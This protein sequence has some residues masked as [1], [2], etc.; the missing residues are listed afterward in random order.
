MAVFAPSFTQGFLTVILQDFF[1]PLQEAV[2]VAVPALTGVILPE[3]LTDAIL[4]AEDFQEM[5]DPGCAVA[6]RVTGL[7]KYTV[8]FVSN[9]KE[10]SLTV[11]L[12]EADIFPAV[13]VMTVVP[14][15]WGVTFPLEFTLAMLGFEE[16]QRTVSS[17]VVFAF[18]FLVSQV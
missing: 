10:G 16:L 13:A 2:M 7:F 15:F 3:A 6:V 14:A 5:V 9:F 18:N 17:E 12:Q 1:N 8:F 4:G 11:T